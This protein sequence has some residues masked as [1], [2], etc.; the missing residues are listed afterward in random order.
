M[1]AH[2]PGFRSIVCSGC[3]AALMA[4]CASIPG[5]GG[6]TAAANGE[7]PCSA[8]TSA[9]IGGVTGAVIGGL[10]NGGKGAAIGAVA[11]AATGYFACAIYSVRT[12]EQKTAQQVEVDY[13]KKNKGQLPATPKVTQYNASINR[14][15]V[16]RGAPFT[17]DSTVE[18][19]NGKNQPVQSVREELTLYSPDG[20]LITK[21]PKSKPFEAT[22]AGRYANTFTLK[23]PEGAPQGDYNIKTKLYVNEQHV[24]SRDLHAK[25]VWLDNQPQIVQV[26][27]LP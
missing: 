3:I 11:G 5:A 24:A 14:A 17:L 18:V 16:Q 2:Y 15:A 10:L 26:A 22:S 19:V 1:L 13:R 8:P 25:V 23:L 12:T 7:N 21:D 6:G 9:I 27:S 4:G 20:K